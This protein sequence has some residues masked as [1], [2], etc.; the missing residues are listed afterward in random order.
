MRPR[1]ASP[2]SSWARGAPGD[3]PPAARQAVRAHRAVLRQV[4]ACDH[5]WILGEQ[6][7]GALSYAECHWAGSAD[8][9]AA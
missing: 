5:A 4:L 7:E 2:D 6:V 8:A 1:P 9:L 3:S